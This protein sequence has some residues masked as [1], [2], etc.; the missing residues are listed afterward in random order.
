MRDRLV[1]VVAETV[2]L[3]CAATS[4]WPVYD[5]RAWMV[6]VA[7]TVVLVIAAAELLRRAG[8]PRVLVPLGSLAVLLVWLVAYRARDA[9]PFGLLPSAGALRALG[10]VLQSGVSDVDNYAAPVPVTPGFALL[11]VGGLGLVAVAIDVVTVTLRRPAA[12][13][14]VLLAVY[15]V[16]GA[17]SSAGVPWWA[18]LL[19]AASYLGLLLAESRDRVGRWGRL[20][21]GPRTQSANPLSVVGRRVGGTALALAVVAPVAV[22]GLDGHALR[23]GGGGPSANG[24]IGTGDP[25]VNLSRDLGSRQKV[26]VFTV[27]VPR[28]PTGATF[29]DQ[30]ASPYMRTEVFSSFTGT[31]WKHDPRG[32]A[33]STSRDGTLFPSGWVVAAGE[34]RKIQVSTTKAYRSRYLPLPY[35]P[36]VVSGLDGT[37]AGN[38]ELHE[39][40]GQGGQTSADMD[41]EVTQVEPDPDADD[42]LKVQAAEP[43][44]AGQPSRRYVDTAGLGD[45]GYVQEALDEAVGPA[46][47]R[48]ERPYAEALALQDWFHNPS[49]AGFAYDEHAPTPGNQETLLQSFLRN[50]SGFC[51]HYATAMVL[52]SRALG[53][54]ARLAIGYLPGDGVTG[55]DNKT[56]YEITTLLAHAWPEL[57]FEGYGWLRFEPTPRND[58]VSTDTP[59]Y[60]TAANAKE[61][62]DAAKASSAEPSSSATSASSTA[63]AKDRDPGLAS[64]A[65]ASG[66]PGGSSSDYSTPVR[67]GVVLLA[68]LALWLLPVLA[69]RRLR[70][71]RLGAGATAAGVGAAWDEVADT[72]LDLGLGRRSGAQ[73]P[74]QYA[75]QLARASGLP[76]T[77]VGPLARLL[78]AYER[79]RFAARGAAMP[80]V[81]ADARAVSRALLDS[82]QATD[83]FRA[84]WVPRSTWS[85]VRAAVGRTWSS[86]AGTV[87]DSAA[88]LRPR[89]LFR[90]RG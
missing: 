11:A 70:G 49:R 17:V 15:A 23:F 65:A 73:T 3:L 89:Q 9:A 88:R 27:S 67:A 69:R 86:A 53:I 6:P 33:D 7:F 83:R 84:R 29:V 55:S 34:E 1:L 5:S 21:G 2:A 82:A 87:S 64:A 78:T 62:E 66:G 41:Y 45:L 14:L 36:K 39:V 24:R 12:A 68:V 42:L 59:G 50:R 85:S 40:V 31:T 61:L 22:P 58:G 13:G 71:R 26:K 60:A 28:P 47:S 43:G 46:A 44:K 32:E 81:S 77:E 48:D 76:L 25:L 18:F 37:W 38:D 79:A 74:R 10:D 63:S 56:T 72:A 51:V 4:L 20:L 16:P 80:D 30:G 52:L 19:G 8:L 90:L 57:W 54:P 75:A 35:A